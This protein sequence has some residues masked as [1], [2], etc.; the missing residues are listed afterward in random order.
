MAEANNTLLD[1][2]AMMNESLDTIPDAPDF[3]TPPAGEYR[4]SCK[5]AAIDKY[6]TKDEPDVPKQRLK[7]TYSI[8]E[9]LS[10]ANNEPPVPDGSIFT[11]T[12]QATEQGL[13]YFKKR[14]KEIMNAGD[15]QGVTL[16]DMMN[17]V[18]GQEFSARLTIKKS[19]NNGKTYENINLRVVNA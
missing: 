17:S 13:G 2:D 4:L 7:L 1:L 9:T 10:T 11:E 3:V 8:I 19:T 12:F 16:G 5:D 18:K 6:T 15:V 14:I